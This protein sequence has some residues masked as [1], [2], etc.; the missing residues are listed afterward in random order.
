MASRSS[1]NPPRLNLPHGTCDTGFGIDERPAA[2]TCPLGRPQFC[3][4]PECTLCRQYN[5]YP[6]IAC[7][8]DD[9]CAALAPSG[10]AAI[11]MHVDSECCMPTPTRRQGWGALKT[12][13]R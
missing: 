8:G 2:G 13:Y 9:L 3:G 7:P 1:W 10:L 4:P 12:L 11:R 6:G 5:G